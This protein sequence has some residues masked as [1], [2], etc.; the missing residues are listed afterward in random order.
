MI[1]FLSNWVQQIALAVIIVSIFELILPNGNLKKYIKII[2]GIYVI[3][4]LISPFVDS[5]ALY[6]LQNVDLSEY[7]ENETQALNSTVNQESMDLRLSQLYIE[8][9]EKDIKK[10]VEENEYKMVKCNID[11]NLKTSSNNPGIHKID[12][13]ISKNNINVSDVEINIKKTDEKKQ[14]DVDVENLKKSIA[15]NYEISK[16]II[17]IKIK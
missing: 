17:N 7:V 4:C 13:T 15:S 11:A 9:L 8:E 3:F 6:K 1:K 10:R 12:L 16:D 5:Q 14:E 2:L